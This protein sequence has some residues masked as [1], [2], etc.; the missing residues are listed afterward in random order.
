MTLSAVLVLLAA[1]ALLARGPVPSSAARPSRALSQLSPTLQELM[2]S[3]VL[4]P[5]VSKVLSVPACLSDPALASFDAQQ[6][7][8]LL[9]MLDALQLGNTN[10]PAVCDLSCAQQFSQLSEECSGGLRSLLGDDLS[11]IGR[12]GTEFFASCDEVLPPMGPVAATPAPA[13]AV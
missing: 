5:F 3:T 1:A 2:D 13:P 7:P 12:L 6:C 11:D 8:G 4:R 9:S 10:P